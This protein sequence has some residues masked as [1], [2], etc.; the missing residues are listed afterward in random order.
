MTASNSRARSG[1]R[2]PAGRATMTP[3]QT[4]T[5]TVTEAQRPSPHR[6]FATDEERYQAIR[7]RDPRA[8]GHFIYAVVTTGVYCRPN[9]GARPPCATT[10]A[11]TA[12]PTTPNAP[13]SGPASAAGRA[14]RR[15]PSGRRRWCRRRARARG[16]MEAASR[17]PACP[18]WRRRRLSTSHFHR[19]FKQTRRHDPAAIRRRLPPAALRRGRARRGHRD[20]RRD[21]R[22]GLL[23]QQPFLRSG[24]GALGMAPTQLRA[25][26]EGLEIRVTM[27]PGSLG[28]VLMAATPRG[29]C[30]MSFGD[31]PEPLQRELRRRFPRARAHPSGRTAGDPT[32][33]ALADRVVELVETPMG[34]AATSRWTWWGPPS[35][36]GSGA[37]CATSRRHDHHVRRGGPADRR[38]AGGAGGGNG[39]RR[40]PG[41]RGR[42][43]PPGPAR[44]RRPGRLR[45]GTG[46]QAGAAGAGSK[47][48]AESSGAQC[49]RR[50]RVAKGT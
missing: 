10:C 13:V 6:P 21:L 44:R 2:A 5:A 16:R 1:V 42:A 33:R 50:A 46:A 49:R 40:Q 36:S 27:P 14:S 48:R 29:V 39:L 9:C 8:E 25:G 19:L 43:L 38:A 23:L 35:S 32:C 15:L 17:C 45:L 41:R 3:M 12:P 4:A 37:R 30:A 34:P 26:R 11:S 20:H 18:T 22:S 24:R 31:R 28:Q 47:R 7:R